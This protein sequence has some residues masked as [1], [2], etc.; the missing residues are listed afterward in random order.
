MASKTNLKVVSFVLVILVGCEIVTHLI[1]QSFSLNIRHI[2]SIPSLAEKI[3]PQTNISVLFMGNSLISYGIDPIVFRD[4]MRAK[5]IG[6][7]Q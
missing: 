1:V 2:R 7:L 3:N 4:E 5:G 6:P